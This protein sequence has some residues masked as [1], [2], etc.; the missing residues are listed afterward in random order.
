MRQHTGARLVAKNEAANKPKVILRPRG[1]ASKKISFPI[2][3][4]TEEEA[5]ALF[6]REREMKSK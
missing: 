6:L 2:Y 4:F 1:K 3:V 5:L